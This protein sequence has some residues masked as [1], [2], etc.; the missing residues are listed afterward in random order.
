MSTLANNRGQKINGVNKQILPSSQL[1]ARSI[2]ISLLFSAIA[3]HHT[4]Q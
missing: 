1:H 2:F 4:G 3:K